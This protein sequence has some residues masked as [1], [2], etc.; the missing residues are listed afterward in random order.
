[1]Y[2]VPTINIS[3]RYNIIT[4][5]IRVFSIFNEY[6]CITLKKNSENIIEEISTNTCVNLSGLTPKLFT[7]LTRNWTTTKP[8]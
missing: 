3:T 8:F 6:E 7:I 5:Y 1:M 2:Q 4:L